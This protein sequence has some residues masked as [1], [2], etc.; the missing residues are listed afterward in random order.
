M[1][2]VFK[3]GL[4]LVM[5]GIAGVTFGA[6]PLRAECYECVG[7]TS[8]VDMNGVVHY[9]MDCLHPVNSGHIS[10]VP[11]STTCSVGAPC[12]GGGGGGGLKTFR[13]RSIAP[14]GTW[15]S[16]DVVVAESDAS[17]GVNC[18]GFVVHRTYSAAQETHL[19][20]TSA[21]IAI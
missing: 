15:A 11:Y 10:C 20:A 12:S 16:D 3:R 2:E 14:D 6:M 21:H 18:L 5:L 13:E 8:W 9:Y 19:I 7:P 17:F 4:N 1:R